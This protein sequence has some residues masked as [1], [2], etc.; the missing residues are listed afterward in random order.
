MDTFSPTPRTTL[1]RIPKRAVYDKAE[2][3]KILDEGYVCHVGFSID[4]QP[5]VI[6]TGYARL[7][8]EIYV[9]G[10]AA[11]RMLRALGE[12]LDICVTVTLIDGF[13]LSRSA[14]H[15]SMNYRS[16]VMLGRARVV[17]D[18]AGKMTAMQCF[19]NHILPER[20]EEVRQPSEQELKA[21]MV[22]ALPL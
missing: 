13:V 20:W 4:G 17:E 9:H 19:T 8:D 21:T 16:V 7:G 11:S 6:P 14:F 2:V 18:A 5:H 12:G 1:H 15:H 22:L 3:Y 10:S